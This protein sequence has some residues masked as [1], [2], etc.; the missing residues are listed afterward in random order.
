MGRVLYLRVVLASDDTFVGAVLWC[1][2]RHL[3]HLLL[4]PLRMDQSAILTHLSHPSILHLLMPAGAIANLLFSRAVRCCCVADPRTLIANVYLIIFGIA[5]DRGRAAPSLPAA[6]T[7]TSCSTTPA[8]ASSTSSWAA[9]SSTST[10]GWCWWQW[11]C[12][13]VGLVLP[14]ARLHVPP[15]EPQAHPAARHRPQSQA[16]K[17]RPA[18]PVS[19]ASDDPQYEQSVAGGAGAYGYSNNTPS[20]TAGTSGQNVNAYGGLVQPTYTAPAAG[21]GA[22]GWGLN[23]GGVQRVGCAGDA[24]RAGGAGDGVDGG[25]L[26][27]GCTGC[28]ASTQCVQHKRVRVMSTMIHDCGALVVKRRDE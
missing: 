14:A 10:G 21:G 22:S 6:S 16:Q 1:R 2:Y 18:W 19:T 8:S 9:S 20:W 7:A 11:Y 17:R 5:D 28:W 4:H 25:S 3:R 12:I 23:V 26:G 13:A 15:H 24:G 27:A